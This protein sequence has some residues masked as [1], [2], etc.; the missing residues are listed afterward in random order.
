MI[1]LQNGRLHYNWL[2]K[3]RSS[4]P[5]YKVLRPE[6]LSTLDRFA[7]FLRTEGLEEISLNQWE[8]TYVNHFPKGEEWKEPVDWTQVFRPPVGLSTVRGCSLDSFGGEWHYEIPP[9]LGRLHVEIK[10][11]RK[12]SAEGQEI[13][14]MTLTARGPFDATGKTPITERLDLGH[15]TIVSA[16]A[17]LTSTDAQ[18]HWGRIK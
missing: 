17:D 13:L 6:F 1:Q 7:E 12:G 8:V 18:S 16:F 10:H 15:E 4:Y 5:R 11:G 2:G 3:D 9:F 14:L